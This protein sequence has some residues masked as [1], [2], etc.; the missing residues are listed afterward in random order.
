[1][2]SVLALLRKS[3]K[4]EI[5]I[6][7]LLSTL[8]VAI[9][10]CR[11]NKAFFYSDDYTFIRLQSHAITE[12]FG[13]F[14]GHFM[15]LIQVIY[16]I[17]IS[18]FGIQSYFPFLILSALCNLFLAIAT[19]HFLKFNNF[20]KPAL[21]LVPTLILIVPFS[22]HTIFWT[23]TAL[24]LVAVGL[25]LIHTTLPT[26]RAFVISTIMMSLF[27]IGIGG[28]GLPIVFGIFAY[29]FFRRKIEPTIA[30]L[31]MIIGSLLIYANMQTS[32]NVEVNKSVMKWILVNFQ[33][34]LST[35]TPGFSQ[36]S[37][38]NLAFELTF[39]IGI[40]LV[41]L[42]TLYRG[43]KILSPVTSNMISV[44]VTLIT[45]VSMIAISRK[46]AE[47]ITASRYVVIA[48]SL[49]T[50]FCLLTCQDLDLRFGFSEKRINFQK[51][52]IVTLLFA[53][54]FRFLYWWQAP[55]DINNQSTINREYVA[56]AV[57]DWRVGKTEA[58]EYSQIDGLI[59]FQRTLDTNQWS[60]FAKVNC[61]VTA[62]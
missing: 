51:T 27:G 4:N 52:L 59:Y 38:I 15:P 24:N 45:F 53:S 16:K 62:K 26:N 60:K 21:I 46:G 50:V 25:L 36:I 44:L 61:P 57:C 43:N 11:S 13:Q 58:V 22:A 8:A 29:N 32:N 34:L 31:V 35:Y 42:N 7:L 23:A 48:T 19:I 54:L 39:Y 37:V 1:M 55:L 9:Q 17:M 41:V 49:F 14:N 20:S 33:I 47:D 5:S 10:T 30:S 3:F 12:V 28:Y 6:A 56:Q 18:L 2:N 40:T